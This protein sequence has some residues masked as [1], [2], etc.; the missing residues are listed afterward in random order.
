MAEGL[1]ELE[2]ARRFLT[3]LRCH[4]HF[5]FGR[6][7]NQFTFDAQESVAGA[8]AAG[9]MRTYFRHARDIYRLAVRTLETSEAQSSNLF[10]QFRDWRARLIRPRPRSLPR[11]PP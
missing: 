9:T 6:D 1:P 11:R 8:D 3:Y 4:L 7:A 5:Q 10:S 2:E